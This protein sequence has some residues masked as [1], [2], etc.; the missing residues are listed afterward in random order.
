M[1]YRV[2][3]RKEHTE[4][5][6]PEKLQKSILYSCLSVREFIGS[7]ELTAEHV[8]RHVEGWLADKAEVTSRDLRLTAARY[9]KQYNPSA[10]LVYET[11]MEV[12]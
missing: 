6:Q 3:K 10:A 11:H 9:L 1:N 5:Y 2:V 4:H 7:A 12:N 8:C